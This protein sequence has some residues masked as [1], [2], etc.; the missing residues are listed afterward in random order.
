MVKE[1][2]SAV[3]RRRRAGLFQMALSSQIQP[4]QIGPKVAG[5]ATER[6]NSPLEHREVRLRGMPP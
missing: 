5:I 1:P 2:R 6:M 4:V 3:A